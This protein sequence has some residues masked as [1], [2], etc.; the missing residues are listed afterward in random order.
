MF[1]IFSAIFDIKEVPRTR[2]LFI[3]VHIYLELLWSRFM[4][5]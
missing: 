2:E 3:V 1:Q 4:H 5:L